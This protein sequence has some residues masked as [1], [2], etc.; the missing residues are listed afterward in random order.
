MTERRLYKITP[1]QVHAAQTRVI[2]DSKLG[3]QTRDAR[4]LLAAKGV[5]GEKVQVQLDGVEYLV[6]ASRPAAAEG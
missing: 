1:S 5:A 2:A 6:D 4:V 3:I